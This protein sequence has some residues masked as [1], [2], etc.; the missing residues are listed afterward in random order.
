MN[1]EKMKPFLLYL[2][3][4]PFSCWAL[5]VIVTLYAIDVLH[6][7]RE[8]NPLGWPFAVFGALI[9]YI[10][11]LI[12]THMLL[13]KIKN[14][15]SLWIAILITSLALG[16][17]I[18]NLLAGLHNIGVVEIYAGGNTLLYDY[19]EFFSNVL[20]QIFFWTMIFALIVLG[21]KEIIAQTAR[22]L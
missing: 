11:A 8:T 12:F 14:R 10:P 3:I 2:Y 5:D 15:L 4:V 18:M 17:G 20:V 13:F 6:V 16:L 9:F 21:I 22:R 7:A 19:A 1:V